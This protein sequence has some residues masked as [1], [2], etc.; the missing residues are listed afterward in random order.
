MARDNRLREA[1][2]ILKKAGVEYIIKYGGKHPKLQF[3]TFDG[4]NIS[5]P[6]PWSPSEQFGLTK[7]R[8]DLRKL[9]GLSRSTN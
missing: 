6:V 5:F 8:H 9:L 3:K 2:S 7:M 1:C 4:R